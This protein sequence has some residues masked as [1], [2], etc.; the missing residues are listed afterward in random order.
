MLTNPDNEIKNLPS[1][2]PSQYSESEKGA[3]FMDFEKTNT[4]TEILL[5]S[6]SLASKTGLLEERKGGSTNEYY[7]PASM[8]TISVCSEQVGSIVQLK[9]IQSEL[10]NFFQL[11]HFRFQCGQMI[12]I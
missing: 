9:N 4:E 1:N 11:T 7:M 3:K 8:D 10:F 6:K 2:A 12:I 5:S